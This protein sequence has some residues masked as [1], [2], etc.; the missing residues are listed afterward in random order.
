[1]SNIF[2][3]TILITAAA[4]LA[5]QTP[6]KAWE[7][8]R[9]PVSPAIA[10]GL[11]GAPSQHGENSFRVEADR[12]CVIRK[13]DGTTQV[14]VLRHIVAATQASQ[15]TQKGGSVGLSLFGWGVSGG[16]SN[17]KVTPNPPVENFDRYLQITKAEQVISCEAASDPSLNDEELRHAKHTLQVLRRGTVNG[18][19]AT[20]AAQ[21]AYNKARIQAGPHHP[22]LAAADAAAREGRYEDATRLLTT[23]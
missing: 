21:A 11:P 4:G 3:G 19:G 6:A 22:K 5:L 16:I 14:V 8:Y 23:N 12:P 1:M 20:E 2:R 10:P 9:G 17:L 13:P 7:V 18:M 15:I